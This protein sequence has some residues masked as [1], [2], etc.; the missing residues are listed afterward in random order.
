MVTQ[1]LLGISGGNSPASPAPMTPALSMASPGRLPVSTVAAEVEAALFGKHGGATAEYKKHARMLRSNLALVGNAELRARI[2][3]GDLGADE[4]VAMDSAHIAPEA[5]REQ[6]RAAELKAMRELVVQELT[7][8]R[9]DS[10]PQGRAEDRPYNPNMAPPPLVSPSKEQEDEAK[11][12]VE[13]AEEAPAAPVRPPMVLP[14][15]PPP[16]PF[17]EAAAGKNLAAGH[18]HPATPDVLATPAPEDE[19]EE[20]AAL[21]RF[22]SAPV[23]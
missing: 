19:D 16:T 5:L 4:L 9:A 13:G 11:E 8:P 10:P 15:E 17:R 23:T 14:M 22:L 21:L 7:P 2:L 20:E 18:E 3:S 6:R 1:G 12:V